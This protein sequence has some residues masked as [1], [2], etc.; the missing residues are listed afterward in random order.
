MSSD[1][2]CRQTTPVLPYRPLRGPIFAQRLPKVG[3]ALAQAIIP[4]LE[5]GSAL[6]L[7]HDSSTNNL[8][9]RYRKMKGAP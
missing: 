4:E 5:A 6:P 2:T 3:K 1:G 9:R 8:I 7:Q